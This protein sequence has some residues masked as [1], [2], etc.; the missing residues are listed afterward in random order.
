MAITDEDMQKRKN[1]V[2]E[3]TILLLALPDE[4]QKNTENLNTKISKLNEELGDY[5]TDLYNYKRGLSQVEARLVEFKEN[6]IKYCKKIKVLERDIELKDYKIKYLKDELEE[7]KKEKESIDFKIEKFKNASKHLDRLL[8]SQKLDKDMKGVGFNEY[9][10]VLPPLAQVYSPSKKDLSWMGL[11]EFV[12]DT[13]TD[14]TRPTPSIDGIPQDNIDD[15]V[16]WDIGCSRHMTGLQVLQMKDGI[17]LSQDKYV[18]D[19]LKKIGYTNIRATKTLMDREN[20]W[21]KDGTRKDVE[22]HLYRSMI[23]SLMYLTASRPNIMFAVCAYARHQV[24]PKECHLH[25]VKRIFR[26]LKVPYGEGSEHP[27]KPHHTPS[28]QDEPIYHEQ[29]SQSPQR[30]QTTSQEPT[31]PSQSHSVISTPR[32]ITRGN[33]QICQ[34]NVPSPRADETTLPIRD[35]RYGEAFPTKTSLDVGQDRENIA[36]TPA[37]PYEA[38][39]RVTSLGGGEGNMQQKLQELID[40]YTSL[41]RQ[42]SLMEERVRSQDLEITQLKT[43][44]KTLKDNERR[45]EGLAQ[46]DAPNTGGWIN[47]RISSGGLSVATPTTRVTRSS[48][49]VVIGSSSPISANIPS[50]SKKDKGKWKMTEPKQHSKEKVLEQLSVQLARDLEAKFAQDDQI[51]KE[52]AKRDSEIARI[53]AKKELEMMIAELDKSNEMVEKHLAQ[54]K[55]Y[56]AQQNKPATKTE[57]RNFYMSI[58]RSNAGWKAKDLK[59]MTFEQIEEKFIPVWEKMQDFIP[60][61]SKLESKRLKRPGIQ[62]DKERFK[63]LKTAE[64]SVEE[65]YI[66]AIEVKYPIIDW[67]IYSKGQRKCWKIIRFGNHT[68]VYQIFEDMLK[69]FD[70]EDLDKLWSLVKKTCSTIEVTDEK[71]KEL[72]VELK[73]LYKPDS[74]DPL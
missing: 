25:V 30:V 17:F 36:K 53:Y 39:P 20:P 64:A 45:R 32:R 50:I 48:R 57:R 7:L 55:K 63:K 66:K 71:A 74:R 56:Q 67:E 40:I 42:H 46:E 21:G 37:M 38:L 27:Y 9:Y 54:I 35:V 49:G 61:N 65:L 19:I 16:Y 33:I 5:K 60:M 72:W 73:R 51:I 26:Y 15:K 28:D 44:V 43:R 70:R 13:V 52:Q 34:S 41:Q 12:D 59:G 29:I 62:L 14:Y 18:G 10:A 3:R 2:K 8:G 68:E 1:D 11:P 24:T 31:I 58:L 23:G 6:E 47:G 22:L 69:K 4:H